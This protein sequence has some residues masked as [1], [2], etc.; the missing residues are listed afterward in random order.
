MEREL[1]VRGMRCPVPYARAKPLAEALA[2]GDVLH[3]LATDPEAPV[4]L[5][6]LAAD[7]GLTCAV[8][9]EDGALRI[10]LRR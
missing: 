1:D 9:H 5:G 6:A 10:T 2:P 4:D 3:V 8:A 7:H